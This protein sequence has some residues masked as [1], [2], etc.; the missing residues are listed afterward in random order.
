MD[1]LSVRDP[2]EVDLDAAAVSVTGTVDADALSYV[3]FL[4]NFCWL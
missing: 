2:R 1:A 3:Q 4:S